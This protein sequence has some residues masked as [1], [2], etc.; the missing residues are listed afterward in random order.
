MAQGELPVVQYIMWWG[1]R[2]H[3]P[4][5]TFHVAA[6]KSYGSK[7]ATMF[8]VG[9]AWGPCSAVY[10]MVTQG[11]MLLPLV[12]QVPDY[13]GVRSVELSCYIDSICDT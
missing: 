1:T 6:T 8:Q 5:A 13:L 3:V 2:F 9:A 12:H 11:S 7:R 4:Q 10:Y